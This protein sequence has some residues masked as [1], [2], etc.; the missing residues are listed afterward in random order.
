MTTIVPAVLLGI[1]VLLAGSLPWGA[2]LAPIN[3]R[4]FPAVPWAILPMAVYLWVYWRYIGGRIG[5]RANA[6]Q[7]RERLRAHPLAPEVWAMALLTGLTGFAALLSLTAVM[8]RLMVM[9]ESGQIVT[10]P[11]M[12]TV[13]VIVL[14]VMASVVAGVTEEAAFRGYM[15]GPIERRYGL[16]TAILVNGV[17]FGLLH[18]P[19]HREA[20]LMMLPY[21]VAVAAVYSGVTWAT[22]S[23]LPAVA[24]HVGGDVWSLSRLWAT[25]QPEWQ[26][27]GG[28]Q[29]LVWATGPDAAFLWGVVL[30]IVLGAATV[31]LCGI[32]RKL[33]RVDSTR[34][35]TPALELEN[36]G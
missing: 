22:N 2:L 35:A 36:E 20:V 10:P 33:A 18:F 9:P 32:L 23:I 16:A 7:R 34:L 15:Q 19:N 3:L 5:P 24:L 4:L 29:P 27:S 28:I 11:A 14:L 1:V 13:T 26:R 25:G 17:M 6:P 21:Y 8:A 31:A 30:L 12:P